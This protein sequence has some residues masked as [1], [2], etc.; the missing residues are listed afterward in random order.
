M[1]HNVKKS[2]GTALKI[3]VAVLGFWFV[4][5]LIDWNDTA[6]LTAGTVLK[7]VTFVKETKVTISNTP[8]ERPE[9][10][11]IIFGTAKVDMR[12]TQPD[13]KAIDL[14]DVVSPA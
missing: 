14:H 6:R 10:L 7:E 11:R 12:L 2:L 8:A 4:A 3:C 13:G 9:N 5:H 1:S